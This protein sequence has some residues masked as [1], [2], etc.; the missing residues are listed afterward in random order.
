MEQAAHFIKPIVEKIISTYDDKP[1]IKLIQSNKKGNYAKELMSVLSQ[2]DHDIF[3]SIV[4]DE[5]EFPLFFLEV[6]F[7][8]PTRDHILQRFDALSATSI[9]G[10]PYVKI[11]SSEKISSSEHGGEINFDPLTAYNLI[12]P[13]AITGL[14]YAVIFSASRKLAIIEVRR[15]YS[16]VLSL[17]DVTSARKSRKALRASGV[18]ASRFCLLRMVWVLT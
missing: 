2:K 11:T 18:L 3:A 7:A 9:A 6:S 17:S 13:N 10:Y 16:R 4:K 1:E 5:K 8:V 15:R 12:I 14:I